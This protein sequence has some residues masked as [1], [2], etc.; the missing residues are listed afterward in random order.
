[1]KKVTKGVIAAAGYG[2]RF[3][4][5]TKSVPKEMLPLIDTPIIHY[6][7]EEFVNSGVKDIIIVTK[8]GNTSIEDYFDS[9]VA[10]EEFLSERGKNDI[11]ERMKKIT[12]MANIAYVRQSKE[13]PYGNA[14]PLLVAK[15]FIGNEN[16]AMAYGDDITI[17]KVPVLKQ[18]INT[19]KNSNCSA[20]L[21]VQEVPME[22][23]VRYNSIKHKK[24]SKNVVEKII[25]KP[26]IADAPTNLAAFG[27]FIFTS[28]IFNY[29]NK[30]EVGKDNELWLTD[31]IHKLAANHKV[32][33]Q[34]IEGKWMTT[35]DPLRYLQ[36]TIEIALKRED[37]SSQLKKYILEKLR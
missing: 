27:R 28:K 37:L 4:P 9:F 24:G 5:A 13:L 6:I 26:N 17:S 33:T 8:Y 20:V 11:L 30:D 15:P 16:F 35:G 19:F 21:A 23:I 2:T 14:S 32:I 22:E 10:L 18:L 29:I 3:L 7:V 31:A 25:E 1:M 34:T 36:T 12:K